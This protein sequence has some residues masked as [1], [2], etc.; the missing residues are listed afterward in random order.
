M[1]IRYLKKM[2]VSGTILLLIISFLIP[3]SY[4]FM[5]FEKCS[6]KENDEFNSINNKLF[7][8][9]ILI[10][11]EAFCKEY[12]TFND[13]HLFGN[14]NI[15]NNNGEVTLS[16][17]CDWV[18]GYKNHGPAKT[19]FF[20]NN[21]CWSYNEFIDLHAGDNVSM[22]WYRNGEIYRSISSGPLEWGGIGSITSGFPSML[23]TGSWYVKVYCNGVYLITGPN[24]VVIDNK[25]PNTP[26]NPNPANNAKDIDININL[27]WSGGDPDSGDNVTY[28]V[29]F[30]GML[31]LQKVASNTS[32]LSYEPGTLSMNTTYFWRIVA[33]DNHGSSSI[34]PIWSFTTAKAVNNPPSKPSKPSGSNL[35]RV[36][37]SYSYSTVAFDP[38][39]D[40]IYYWF[41]WGDDTDSGWDGPHNSGDNVTVSH[42]WVNVGSFPIKVKAKDVHGAES[43]WSDPLTISM[44]KTYT[45]NPIIQLF[46][47]ALDSFL[48][49]GKI[50]NQIK[51]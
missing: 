38:E 37:R 39:N 22:V 47:K 16:I 43:V 20:V 21:P 30:G 36:G 23:H 42:I 3:C 44:S 17:M 40:D 7:S 19:E 4:G 18:I 46:R 2:L 49:M 5:E 25:P 48:Y 14:Q 45:Y 35:V 32:I 6:F 1:F 8:E 28:D 41:D 13:M 27:S 11:D 50:L 24:F 33:W 26:S 51:L 10:D 34:G 31:T 12:N 29:Y 9:G 15:I